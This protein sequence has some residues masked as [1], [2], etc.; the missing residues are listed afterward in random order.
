M[1]MCLEY[2]VE[3][4][5]SKK[6]DKMGKKDK[7]EEAT[8]LGGELMDLE[9]DE[10]EEY[11]GRHGDS[12]EGEDMEAESCCSEMAA[13]TSLSGCNQAKQDL[14]KSQKNDLTVGEETLQKLTN[15]NRDNE[16]DQKQNVEELR[17]TKPE[18]VRSSLAQ[19]NNVSTGRRVEKDISPSLSEC[20]HAKEDQMKSQKNALAESEEQKSRNKNQE[21]VAVPIQN[22]N[23]LRHLTPEGCKERARNPPSLTNE[24]DERSH[25]KNELTKGRDET[26]M[27]TSI[28]VIEQAREYVN[29]ENDLVESQEFMQKVKN[30]HQVNVAVLKENGEA[31]RLSRP[32]G[33]KESAPNIG[34]FTNEQDGILIIT[35]V[36]S[37]SAQ[38]ECVST[39]SRDEMDMNT[40][41]SVCDQAKDYLNKSQENDLAARKE[42]MQKLK[43]NSQEYEAVLKQNVEALRPMRPEGGKERAPNLGSF[44]S[45]QDGRLIITGVRSSL[46]QKKNVSNSFN[47]STLECYGCEG[48]KEQNMWKRKGTSGRQLQHGEVILLTD[49]S[50]PPM[51]PTKSEKR[52]MKIMRREHGSIADL[53]TDLLELAKDVE[54][55]PRSIVLIHSLSHMAR[56]GT[57]GYIEDLLASASQIKS[58]I[59]QHVQVAP[60]PPL[61][62]GGCDCPLTIRT[63]SEITRWCA[64][65]FGEEGLFLSKS[66]EKAEVLVATVKSGDDGPQVDHKSLM[67]L[68]VSTDWPA[69]RELWTMGGFHLV[70]KVKPISS[71][72]EAKIILTIIEELRSQLAL[73]LDP[74]P[75][76]DRSSWKGKEDTSRSD[77]K[78]LVIG[79]CLARN[80]SEAL[81]RQQQT[82]A[83]VA[84]PDWRINTGNVT[85][86][87][88]K[89][90]RA[91]NNHNPATLILIGLEDS[92]YMAQSE[93]GHTCPALKANDGHF[94]VDGELVVGSKEIQLKLLKLLNPVWDLA[95]G[96]KLIVINP[97]LRYITAGCCEDPEHITN[98]S[99][100]N[101]ESSL[102]S[103][104][105]EV[106]NS[107]KV[108]LK[109]GGYHHCRV[110][111]P[112]MDM[113]GLRTEDIWGEEDPVVPKAVIFDRMAAAME[114]IEVRINS[115]QRKRPGEDDLPRPE[116]KRGRGEGFTNNEGASSNGS[117]GRIEVRISSPE[118]KR[119]GEDNLLRPEAKRGRGEGFTN[120]VVARGNGSHGRSSW[121]PS[122]RGPRP[123]AVPGGRGH[124]GQPPRNNNRRG[125]GGHSGYGGQ[126]AGYDQTHWQYGGRRGG[127]S[128]WRGNQYEQ[129]SYNHSHPRRRF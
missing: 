125:S 26:D 89:A 86:L 110:M 1:I 76:L 72:M 49:Q 115:P 114:G 109:S 35:E 30:N 116:A 68:P 5:L 122:I 63:C 129:T 18:G 100:E 32:E 81:A 65:V 29:Q 75:I 42:F 69:T 99:D 103:R 120:N 10:G 60:L 74:S 55:G 41:M 11:L 38:K 113:A 112:G 15:N 95:V 119:P 24:Q 2:D 82:V 88:E 58:V 8:N 107:M 61:Y 19:K 48:H 62:L 7:V 23:E 14:S 20:N 121:T 52:C 43:N 126:G 56:A 85:R 37:S 12:E 102:R 31:L 128:D 104:L 59:G 87:C 28:S 79:G 47:I 111:D 124:F 64:K 118:R 106:K 25:K 39:E 33:A 123:P 53:T 6:K 45:E 17:A 34:S 101:F 71:D 51:I 117:D 90:S 54:V 83:T 3:A 80:L 44:T 73:D 67:R 84:I 66:F 21:Y 16:A 91:I 78:Y 92:F 13:N 108:Y 98:R 97:M 96:R 57:V 94:H 9:T 40:S 105:E 46:P 36:N 70:T 22:E 77:T 93:S 27:N 127:H 4:N 50:Y